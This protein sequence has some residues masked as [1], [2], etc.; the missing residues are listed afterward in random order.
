MTV[1]C[2]DKTGTITK[3][4]MTVKQIVLLSPTAASSNE[5]PQLPL[6]EDQLLSY[7]VLASQLSKYAYSIVFIYAVSALTRT[8]DRL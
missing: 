1:L 3:N 5:I 6:T 4:E 7:G 8:V 2:S